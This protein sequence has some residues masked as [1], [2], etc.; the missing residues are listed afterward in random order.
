MRMNQGTGIMRD[1][2][3]QINIVL[4]G[5][6]MIILEV[7]LEQAISLLCKTNQID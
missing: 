6:S 2:S 1:D 4:S 3:K 7:S 5:N